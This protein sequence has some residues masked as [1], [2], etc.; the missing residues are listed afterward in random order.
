MSDTQLYLAIGV[1]AL[2]ALMNTAVMLT[3]FTRLDN[4]IR[5]LRRDLNTLTGKVIDLMERAR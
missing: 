4:D 3:L 2:L 5:E 1:P